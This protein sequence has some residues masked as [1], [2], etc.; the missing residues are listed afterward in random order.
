LNPTYRSLGDHTETTEVEYDPTQTNYSKLLD[1]FWKNHDSTQKCT[2]QYM[3]AVF[4]HNEEQKCLAEES[5]KVAQQKKARPIQTQILKATTFYE[6]EDYH[7]KYLLQQHPWLMN[8]LDID[9]GP[10]LNSSHI[11]TRLNGY[12]GGYGTLAAFEAELPKLNLDDKTAEYVR[13]AIQK[14]SR[15]AC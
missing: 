6:A 2:R 1:M 12:V 14:G 5:L 15:V 9:P 11:A 13:R 4:Y 3:S 8:T 7:Q 10:D